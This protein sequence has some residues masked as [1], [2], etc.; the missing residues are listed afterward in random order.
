VDGSWLRLF[1]AVGQDPETASSGFG[2]LITTV[3][4]PLPTIR[5]ASL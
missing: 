3:S 5:T 2:L 4:K 1:E